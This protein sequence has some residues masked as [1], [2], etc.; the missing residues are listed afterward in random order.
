M[1]DL[2][3]KKREITYISQKEKIKALSIIKKERIRRAR[4]QKAIEKTSIYYV[5][6]RFIFS[7]Y[8]HKIRY[9]YRTEKRT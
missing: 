3:E 6:I 5:S 9:G 8:G 7:L 4:S 1:L 2:L